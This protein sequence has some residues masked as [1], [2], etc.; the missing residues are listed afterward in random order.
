MTD[1]LRP[2]LP[3]W[4]GVSRLPGLEGR[5]PRPQR[6]AVVLATAGSLGD[7]YPVLSI[8][9][10]LEE[11]GVETRLLLAPDQCDIARSWGLLATPVGPTRAQICA[12][13]G[14]T[15]DEV[16]AA[17]FRNPMPFLRHVTQSTV[18]EVMPE[19]ELAC[20]GASC[21]SG[22][23]FAFG[24]AFAAEKAALPYV[25]LL[26]QPMLTYSTLDPG[27]GPGFDLMDRA[28]QTAVTRGWNRAVFT[29]VKSVMR[30]GLNGPF[31]AVRAG[32]GLPP[33][34]GTPLIDVGGA[35]VPLRLGLWSDAFAMV[36]RDAPPD[37]RAVG[38]PR[39]P[40]GEVAQDVQAWLD[41]GPPPLVVTL[42][43]IAQNL[44]GDAFYDR[45]V[46]LARAMGLRALVLHGKAAP[47]A[48]APDV[49]AL[50]SAP[51]APLFP[52]AAAI[53]HHGGMG[54]TAEALRAA[55]PQLIVPIGGDQPDNAAKLVKL[56]AAVTLSP[57][58][59][60]PERALPAIRALLER[61]DYAAAKDLADHIA[62]EDG[63]QAAAQ[64]LAQVASLKD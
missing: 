64:H 63:A 58:R 29:V 46:A 34:R 37:L 41:A 19:V 11:M 60:T 4:S 5:I 57:K 30:L 6:G 7:L 49:L 1:T 16:A 12:E 20:V 45:A 31:N 26:L 21:V 56:G 39:A 52:Q 36:P 3:Q 22:T 44:G 50:P 28:P 55:R 10:S 59:F 32:M 18:A 61:F 23:L 17:F 42:G 8:A 15:E 43:S 47:P 53:L 62:A 48:P 9:T 35:T 51:H 25:P 40:L 24:A 2:P 54:T 27:R 33:F 38:F 14:Q 13:L